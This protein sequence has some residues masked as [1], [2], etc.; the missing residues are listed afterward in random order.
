MSSQSV[1]IFSS[2]CMENYKNGLLLASKFNIF[3]PIVCFNFHLMP[4]RLCGKGGTAC[5]DVQQ[6]LNLH[7]CKDLAPS[8]Q[9]LKNLH[10]FSFSLFERLV[11]RECALLVV[12]A[13]GDVQTEHVDLTNLV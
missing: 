1:R 9:D 3:F 11:K 7:T 8:N 5:H 2:N 13:P 12:Q 6:I 4:G 10:T